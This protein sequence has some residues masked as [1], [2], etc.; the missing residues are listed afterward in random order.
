MF[1]SIKKRTNHQIRLLKQ[2]FAQISGSPFSEI[3]SSDKLKALIERQVGD[4]RERI[5]FP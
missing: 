5:F 2:R 4:F 3:L 1:I